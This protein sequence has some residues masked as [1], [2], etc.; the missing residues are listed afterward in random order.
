MTP[1]LLVYFLLYVG[2]M[3]LLLSLYSYILVPVLTKNLSSFNSNAFTVFA[4]MTLS[5]SEFHMERKPV[6][7]VSDKVRF[8]PVS[9]ATETS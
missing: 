5:G 9:S 6:F 7:E 2:L 4:N 8:K 3:R 1:A